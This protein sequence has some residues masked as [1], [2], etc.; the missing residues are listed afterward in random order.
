MSIAWIYSCLLFTGLGMGRLYWLY[1]DPNVF[2]YLGNT[3]CDFTPLIA[4]ITILLWVGFKA[5]ELRGT[6][7]FTLTAPLLACCILAFFSL[8][9]GDE[10]SRH[11]DEAQLDSSLY[12]LAFWPSGSS[13]N[14]YTLFKC[15]LLGI[16]CKDVYWLPASN[17]GD[18][19]RPLTL[20]VHANARSVSVMNDDEVVYTY[21]ESPAP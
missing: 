8:A 15:D 7:L 3:I 13:G 11:L 14:Y 6:Q 9:V 5:R 18:T 2:V 17:S 12:R 19:I 16:L 1:T 20:S 21:R 4:L 10:A